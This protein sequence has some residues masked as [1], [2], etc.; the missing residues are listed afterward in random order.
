MTKK[1]SVFLTIYYIRGFAPRSRAIFIAWEFIYKVL[2]FK[3]GNVIINQYSADGQKQRSD[4]Y[5]RLTAITPVGENTVVNPENGYNDAVYSY[6]GTAYIGGFEYNVSK[7]KYQGY[8]G[9]W[10]YSDVFNPGKIYTPEGYID[11][12]SATLSPI[13]SNGV[14]YNYFRK[15]HLGNIREVWNGVRKNYSNQVKEAASTR[16]RTQYYP[17]GLP[18]AESFGAAVQKHKYNDK[19][20]IE[21]HG[22]DE[23]DSEARWYYP[24]IMRTTTID[25]LAEKYYSISPYAW[26][27]NNPVRNV[28]PDGRVISTVIGTIVGGIGG[29][30]NAAIQGTDI[31]AGVAEGAVAGFITGGAVDLTVATCGLGGIALVGAATAAGTLSGAAGGVLGDITNQVVSQRSSET[32]TITTENFGSKALFGSASGFVG[33]FGSG[34]VGALGL[35][36]KNSTQALQTTMIQGVVAN[37]TESAASAV[38]N[39]VVKAATNTGV[40]MMKIDAAVSTITS[41]TTTVVGA[42]SSNQST[43]NTQSTKSNNSQSTN[44]NN[45]QKPVWQLY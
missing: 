16:Q 2:Q 22:L 41:T 33:G 29:G 38:T 27:G 37:T 17:S 5:T 6:T 36:A 3:N 24:A 44:S 4:N 43:N 31:L 12:L 8:G 15:D 7:T 19:E 21:M 28:D 35:V 25:P 10:I 42:S 11:N 1:Y 14:R 40:S 45:S 39:G 13:V 26:C 23:Y 20:F 9:V 30:I 18:W 34:A 32:I